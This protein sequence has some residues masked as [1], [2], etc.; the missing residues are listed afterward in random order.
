MPRRIK[1]R[2]LSETNIRTDFFEPDEIKA[3]ISFLPD[4]LQDYVR[5]AHITGWR[6]N[7]I[8]SLQW[9][10]VS[11]QHRIIRLNPDN[12]KTGESRILVLTGELLE[13]LKRRE[14]LRAVGCPYVF[15]QRGEFIRDFRKAWANATKAAG[16]SGRVFHSLRRSSVRDIIKVKVYERVAM[17]VSGHCTRSVFDRYNITAEDDIRQALTQTQEYREKAIRELTNGTK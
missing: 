5:F 7:E 2:K 6:R 3:V 15:H 4:Y 17:S 16:C 9:E 14:Q 11:I 10:D 13:L 1:I 8:S 12:S